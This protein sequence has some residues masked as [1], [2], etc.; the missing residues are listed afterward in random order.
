[1]HRQ[2]KIRSL[3]M[4]YA[5]QQVIYITCQRYAFQPY[6]VRQKIRRLCAEAS[7]GDPVDFAALFAVLT[8]QKSVRRIAMEHYM[9]ETKLY[10]M[11]RRFYTAWAME[12]TSRKI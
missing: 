6:K 7:R 11:R 1:M 10:D 2:K 5:A 9:S 4:S 3:D 12:K 8:E